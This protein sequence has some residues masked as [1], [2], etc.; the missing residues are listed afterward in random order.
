MKNIAGK[1]FNRSQLVSGRGDFVEDSV[2]NYSNK[3]NLKKGIGYKSKILGLALVSPILLSGCGTPLDLLPRGFQPAFY[4]DFEDEQ[5]ME[6]L[7]FKEKR[8]RS[9]IEE[10]KK[11][12]M[13]NLLKFYEKRNELL[14]KRNE[15][16]E[17]R[18]RIKSE[19]TKE[20]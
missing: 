12:N 9:E 11:E 20:L 16:L 13:E 6:R 15:L 3:K 8:E 14:K 18:E 2:A 4:R 10:R 5:K 19:Y 1:F 7:Y 17:E